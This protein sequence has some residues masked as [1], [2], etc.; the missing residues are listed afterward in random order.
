MCFK[1]GFQKGSLAFKA[2]GNVFK[3]DLMLGI[4][5]GFLDFKYAIYCYF[6]KFSKWMTCF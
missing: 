4:L 6:G 1:E 3:E 5:K 2:L